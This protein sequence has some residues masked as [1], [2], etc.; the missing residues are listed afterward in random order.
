MDKRS[1]LET[2]AVVESAEPPALGDRQVRDKSRLTSGTGTGVVTIA[3]AALLG[4]RLRAA[5]ATQLDDEETSASPEKS[6]SLVCTDL[7]QYL[8]HVR[9]IID[10]DQHP[11]FL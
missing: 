10:V 2:A 1:G 11:P 5:R 8:T 3:L 4:R 6:L 7:R 9:T